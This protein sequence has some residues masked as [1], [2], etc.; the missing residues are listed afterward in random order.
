MKAALLARKET[1]GSKNGLNYRYY[2]SCA[3]P[4]PA[5]LAH[6]PR[7]AQSHAAPRHG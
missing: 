6:H 5:T 1:R 3:C 4:I 2:T 7:R